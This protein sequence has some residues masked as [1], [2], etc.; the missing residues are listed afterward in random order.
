[1]TPAPRP[2]RL[3]KRVGPHR[4]RST[5]P[6][7]RHPWPW[8]LVGI[9]G[10]AVVGSLVTLVIAIENRDALVRDDYYKEGKAINR[11]LEKEQRARALGVRAALV[12]DAGR[13]VI[14]AEL[15]GPGIEKLDAVDLALSHA[16]LA[17]KDRVIELV[18]AP[19]GRYEA[20][21]E[22]DLAG[23]W[24][25]WLEP[26]PP[27]GHTGPLYDWRL[28]RRLRLPATKPIVLGGEV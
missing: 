27:E 1:M 13:G 18:K 17:S 25:V 16:T 24:H 8:F 28:A 9:T 21:L 20:P 4:P 7:Y 22:G 15:S 10:S 11:R 26:R 3:R 5:G 14:Q 23:R 12:F 6:W 19:D 2:I